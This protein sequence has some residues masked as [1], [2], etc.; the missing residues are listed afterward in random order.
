MN[1]TQETLLKRASKRG[2]VEVVKALIAANDDVNTADVR[3]IVIE[4]VS[5]CLIFVKALLAANADVN[6]VYY[7]RWFVID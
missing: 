4:T 6:Q 2:H 1:E 5:S 7:V 3:R